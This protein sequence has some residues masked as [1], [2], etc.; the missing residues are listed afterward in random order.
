MGT[1]G[2][3]GRQPRPARCRRPCRAGAELGSGQSRVLPG[4]S[5]SILPVGDRPRGCA[6]LRPG[7]RGDSRAERPG[8]RCHLSGPVSPLR[9]SVPTE[10]PARRGAA[11]VLSGAKCLPSTWRPRPSELGTWTNTPVARNTRDITMR[12]APR[13]HRGRPSCGVGSVH[14]AGV[15][16]AGR[17]ATGAPEQGTA[18]PGAPEKRSRR[19]ARACV[20]ACVRTFVCA[21]A[22]VCMCVHV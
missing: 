4:E 8:A 14:G 22:H 3:C 13:P 6:A 20:R 5:L 18:R 10:K 17:A 19:G 7:R 11:T 21:C 2:A 16:R 12:V 1:Q 9:G 15:V